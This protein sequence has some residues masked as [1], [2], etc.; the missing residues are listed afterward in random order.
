MSKTCLL[1]SLLCVAPSVLNPQDPVKVDPSHYKVEFENAQ[2][3]V[4][5]IRYGPHEKSVMHE[6]PAGVAVFLTDQ[7]VK[8]GTP[9]GK[10]QEV[11]QKIGDAVWTPAGKHLPENLSDK[12][13]E[14]VLVELKSRRAAA[15]PPKPK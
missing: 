1:V 7:T 5:R 6:H 10:S 9:D 15:R 4:L 13:L 8:F 12:P 3:R 11:S 14:L 2:V